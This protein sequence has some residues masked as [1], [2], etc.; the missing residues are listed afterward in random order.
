MRRQ[1]SSHQVMVSETA[2][3]ANQRALARELGIDKTAHYTRPTPILDRQI[4]SIKIP[5]DHDATTTRVTG[6]GLAK[7]KRSKKA[8]DKFFGVPLTP[9][10][11]FTGYCGK[12]GKMTK[13]ELAAIKE[14]QFRDAF[15]ATH[16]GITRDKD[17]ATTLKWY[18]FHSCRSSTFRS[19]AS[20]YNALL[21]A[22]PEFDF[23]DPDRDPRAVMNEYI[24]TAGEDRIPPKSLNS[25][26]VAINFY[27][28]AM[29]LD[30]PLEQQKFLRDGVR[31]C[32]PL[33][34]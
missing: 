29:G 30:G 4:T 9:L 8:D 11:G 19:Y 25:Y 16:F 5:T 24:A 32:Q 6:L 34:R 14:E 23:T 17:I 26:T 22:G 27:A 31:S 7:R 21:H 2:Y 12:E 13:N 18:C 1:R 3:Y 10:G 28:R 20:A 15:I 33:H